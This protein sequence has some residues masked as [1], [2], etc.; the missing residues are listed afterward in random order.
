MSATPLWLGLH[1]TELPLSAL[2][3]PRPPELRIVVERQRLCCVNA[4]AAAAGLRP[5]MGLASAYALAPELKALERQPL[6]EA[7][8]LAQLACW[9]YGI[10]QEVAIAEAN[11]LLLEVGS[12]LRL[13]GGL[14][15]LLAHAERE[16]TERGHSVAAGLATTPKAAWLAAHA[17]GVTQLTR[18]APPAPPA[19]QLAHVAPDRL[20]LDAATLRQFEQLGIASLAQL[21]ALPR[22]ALGKR[23]G[24]RLLRYLQQ[25]TGERPDPQPAFVLPPRFR[26]SLPFLDG[27]HDRQ[28]LLFPMKRLLGELADYLRARQLACRGL[29]WRFHDARTLQAE[30][31]IGLSQGRHDPTP[32]LELT[33]LRLE[34]LELPEPVFLLEL[35]SE[36]FTATDVA[37]LTLFDE[38]MAAASSNRAELLDKLIARLGSD[39][40]QRPVALEQHWPEAAMA[41]ATPD[42]ALSTGA[43][44]P[45]PAG[46]RPTWLLPLPEP[47]PC[48]EGRPWHGGPLQLVRG[49]E[50]IDAPWWQGLSGSRDYFEAAT[51][52]GSRCWIFR[53]AASGGWF[54]HGLFG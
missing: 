46:P 52:D 16:L 35:C 50:R 3:D 15:R 33:R 40:L 30:L 43:V 11:T 45:S 31:P 18:L 4:T 21:L 13:Y 34:Q 19:T 49:P 36:E 47:L 54:L 37:N 53:C 42:A 28:I 7:A 17:D 23:F 32:F 20:P 12:C 27:I 48:R 14:T 51:A 22:A 38:P 5:G 10:V 44:P 39:A 2:A 8:A 29:V 25:L 26:Q 24:Q 6:R 1:F 41:T 9:A